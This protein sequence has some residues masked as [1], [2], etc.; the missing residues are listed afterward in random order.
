LPFAS[1]LSVVPRL[2]IEEILMQLIGMLDSPYVRRVAIAMI[3]AKTPF[4]HRP[5]S[6]FRHI[7]QF[8]ELNP[9]LKAPTLITDDGATLMDSNVILDYLAC[10]D[11]RVAALTP[12]NRTQRLSALRAT[13]VALTVMEKAVQRVY[14]RMLRP[15]EK[16]HEPW[17]DRVMGQLTAGL[18]ALEA[19]LP[20]SGWIAG[21][22][23]LADITAACAFGFTQA[24]L[25]DVVEVSR[26]PNL[27][28]FCVR[29][30]ALSAFRAA[31]PEDGATA[32]AVAD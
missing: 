5:I 3:I 6:L 4:I 7:D 32:S 24:T 15:A 29:A 16:Q 23:G 27:G 21:D 17:I 13:G 18:C 8:S 30:E 9:L 12:S 1:F 22:L 31:P 10:V 25:A 26:Y 19:E 2:A 20:G 11:P 28:A 14:E